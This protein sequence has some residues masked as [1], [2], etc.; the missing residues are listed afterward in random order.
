MLE[1]SL[2]PALRRDAQHWTHSPTARNPHTFC[3]AGGTPLP[4]SL[5]AGEK[6]AKEVV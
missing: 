2:P 4:Q 5:T 6:M 3:P 1:F